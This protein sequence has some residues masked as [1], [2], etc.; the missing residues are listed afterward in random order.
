MDAAADVAERALAAVAARPGEVVDLCRALLAAPSPTP[1]GDERAA[2]AGV[3]AYVEGLPGATVRSPEPVPRRRNIVAAAGGRPGDPALL[4][5]G[6][7]D[8][9]GLEGAWTRD[10]L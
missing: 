5:T 3:A 4:L 7:L 8:T 10:P 1:P 2:A 6:H 9:H